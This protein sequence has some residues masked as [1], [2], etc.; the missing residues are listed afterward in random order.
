MIDKQILIENTVRAIK[1]NDG[2]LTY[3]DIGKAL[4]GEVDLPSEIIATFYQMMAVICHNIPFY[5]NNIRKIRELTES[6]RDSITF[7]N[8]N[9]AESEIIIKSNE[10]TFTSIFTGFTLPKFSFG[11]G[12]H[13]TFKSGT[14]GGKPDLIGSD[15]FEYEVKRNYA[16]GSRSGLHK[17]DYLIDC[18]NTTIEIRKINQDN[19]VDL[20]YPPLA[21]FNGFLSNKVVNPVHNLDE[22]T[23]ALIESGELI[24]EIE[25]RLH[26]LGFQW[27][28]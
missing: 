13:S 9:K 1:K 20:M 11:D 18:K 2:Q 24:P 10:G 23:M 8:A 12:T 4:T 19:A 6:F 28:P 5:E 15:G 7:Y 25:K 17:A 27:N 26:E 3:A 21:R 22:E 16:E 14:G